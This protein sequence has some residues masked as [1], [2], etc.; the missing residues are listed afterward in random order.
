MRLQL[1][2]YLIALLCSLAAG[3][4]ILPVQTLAAPVPV[5]PMPDDEP[6]ATAHELLA[7]IEWSEAMRLAG[8]FDRPAITVSSVDL[9]GD[10]SG[11]SIS[12]F[13]PQR[14][15]TQGLIRVTDGSTG[16]E[17]FTLRAPAGE[18]GFGD[19][20]AIVSDA[21]GDGRPDIGVWSWSNADPDPL[22]LMLLVRL[23]VYS[24]SCG[25]MIGL[26]Q[27]VHEVGAPPVD[28]SQFEIVVAGDANQDQALDA[29]DVVDTA[30]ALSSTAVVAPAV[31]CNA[32][33]ALTMDDFTAV[34]DRVAEEP[35][36]QR[37]AIHSMAL[38]NLSVVEP[39][40]APGSGIDPSEMGGGAGGAGG[41]GSC[42]LG[43]QG[44]ATC[45]GRAALLGIS[46]TKLILR[47]RDCLALGGPT[48]PAFIAC[49]LM[50]ICLFLTVIG[51]LGGF[52]LQC[53]TNGTCT[54]SWLLG[55]A[56]GVA[57]L[58][59]LCDLG[60]DRLGQ[61]IRNMIQELIEIL[62]TRGLW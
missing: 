35:M 55:L 36:V 43:W 37:V 5:A 44:G 54:P 22:S 46:L 24:G 45:W 31:D 32:D 42:Q 52:I 15:E 19:H 3:T 12:V 53:W 23:R 1:S 28:L 14:L 6:A 30:F 61:D 57:V 48:S 11:D 26:L 34:I 29:H 47:I 60:L 25:E 27:A 33:G 38:R 59:G 56:N 58:G 10:G 49:A 8:A 7:F 20:A 9:T 51:Q 16:A 13:P 50:N 39:I 4:W 2:R 17:R 40:A 18:M 41:G 21:D 62:L